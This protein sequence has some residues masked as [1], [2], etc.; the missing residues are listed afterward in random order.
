MLQTM[1]GEAA[2][3]GSK[4]FSDFQSRPPHTFQPLGTLEVLGRNHKTDLYLGVKFNIF[5]FRDESVQSNFTEMGKV[6]KMFHYP[7]FSSSSTHRMQA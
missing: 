6:K 1:E 3:V 4:G 7:F 5:I 2:V